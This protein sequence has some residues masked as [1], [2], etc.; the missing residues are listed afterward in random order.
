MNIDKTV[1]TKFCSSF[2]N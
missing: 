1:H 2:H